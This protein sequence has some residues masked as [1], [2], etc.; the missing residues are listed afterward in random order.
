MARYALVIIITI[1]AIQSV[2]LWANK[3]VIVDASTR[4]P[5]PYASIYN[6]NGAV[7]G[8]SND[9]GLLPTIPKE[10]Y[11]VSVRYIGFNDALI[12]YAGAD[13]VFMYE[14][15]S[16][17]PEIVVESKKNR[18]LHVI[19][20]VREYSTLTTY[21]DTVFMFREKIV[22]YMFP[23]N[24][25][26]RFKGWSTPRLLKCRSYY[27]FTDGSGLDSVSDMCQHHFS[28]S[29]WVGV[30]P[31]ST[32]PLRLKS[33]DIARD[34]LYGKYSPA[35]IWQK[36]NYDISVEI[37]V[38]ADT[39]TR[40]WVPNLSVFFRDD[41][42]FEQIKV[43]YNY[44]D[45]IGDVLSGLDLNGYTF[46]I[47][48]RGRGHEMFR[49]NRLNEPF[50]VSTDADIIILDKEFIKARDARKWE[51]RKFKIDADH[52]YESIG[53]PPLEEPIQNLVNRVNSIDKDSIRL[54]QK[55]DQRMVSKYY[56]RKKSKNWIFP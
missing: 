21:S 24:R 2:Q 34:T 43:T 35:I 4:R 26:M 50:F 18:V 8:V 54:K 42:E 47:K 23:S 10:C 46:S 37:N 19:A 53:I 6:Q 7:I 48:S 15:V 39:T 25:K 36:N 14:S 49:F 28:W 31:K 33:H 41:L 12:K 51:N 27:R 56:G 30:A 9:E 17:L 5:L 44:S 52:L 38:L 29:D 1:C 40:K 22:D 32:L 45:V 16:E 13:T 20:L 55:P 11:P 3:T